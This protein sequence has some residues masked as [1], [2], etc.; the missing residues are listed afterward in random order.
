[1]DQLVPINYDNVIRA[2]RMDAIFVAYSNL[3]SETSAADHYS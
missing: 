3:G 2:K 1:M